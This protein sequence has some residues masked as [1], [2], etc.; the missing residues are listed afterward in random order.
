[1]LGDWIKRIMKSISI[2]ATFLNIFG[3]AKSSCYLA[4]NV[5]CPHLFGNEETEKFELADQNVPTVAMKSFE[6][7][8]EFKKDVEANKCR[9]VSNEVLPIFIVIIFF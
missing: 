9:L 3:K 6:R 5:S 8:A 2:P 1:M 4:S 7:K